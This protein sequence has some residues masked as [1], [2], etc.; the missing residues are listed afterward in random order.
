MVSTS[1]EPDPVLSPAAGA[2]EDVGGLGSEAGD[3]PV[4]DDD[5]L[6]AELCVIGVGTA[7]GVGSLI[8]QAVAG[9]IRATKAAAR[10]G[11]P[12]RRVPKRR[13]VATDATWSGAGFE[14]AVTA[15]RAT[16]WLFEIAE[17]PEAS[18]RRCE[19]GTEDASSAAPTSAPPFK[20]RGAGTL[21]SWSRKVAA[22]GRAAG[23]LRRA[24]S[25]TSMR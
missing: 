23:S 16:P 24:V 1:A 13:G 6:G 19:E 2:V 7:D 10:T 17:Y 9:A 4:L 3:G 18:E 14:S 12:L 20:M 21:A 11:M 25:N 15:V 22:V 8:S 5:W